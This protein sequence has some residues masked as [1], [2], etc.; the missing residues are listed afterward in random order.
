MPKF[1]NITKCWCGSEKIISFSEHYLICENCRTLIASPRLSDEFYNSGKN[2]PNFYGKDYWTSYIEKDYGLPDIYERS[3]SDLSD[4]CLYWL[5]YILKYKLPPARTLEL[6]CAHGGLVHL[7]KLVGY[8]SCGTEM[9]PW[10]CDYASV[11]FNISMECGCIEDL[12]IAP[13]SLD[14]I[15]LMDVLEHMTDPEGSLNV[16]ARVLKDDG[17]FV[18]QTPCFRNIKQTYRYLKETNNV[19]L[20]MLRE[21]EHL[22]LFNIKSIEQILREVGF[23]YIYFEPQYF[24]YDMFLFASKTKPV[25]HSED[26]IT[27]LL[28]KTPDGRS[29]LAMIDLFNQKNSLLSK[30]EESEKDRGERLKLINE[31]GK[32]LE[33]SEADREARLIVIN[34]LSKKLE[35]SEEDREARLK[36]I[37]E[38]SKKLRESE[39]IQKEQMKDIRGLEQKLNENKE[40]INKLNMELDQIK[41]HWI[42]RF[43]KR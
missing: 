38:L 2:K 20:R 24:P 15:I 12:S 25:K 33:E 13:K 16:I 39:M 18:I 3:R 11:T 27:E 14:I 31:L 30:L 19:F 40:L 41:K 22:Y 34:K 21:K 37:N 26:D 43:I 9:S 23:K 42:Y 7:M 29:V 4:R 32:K 6:G 1:I 17:I 35:E 28:L 10:I 36:V 8:D 5:K